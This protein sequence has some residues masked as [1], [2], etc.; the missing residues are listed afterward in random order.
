MAGLRRLRALVFARIA[1]RDLTQAAPLAETLTALSTFADL[2]TDHALQFAQTGLSGRFGVPRTPQGEIAVPVILGMGKLGGGELNFSSDIDLIFAFSESG[3]TD[4][5]KSISN[6]EYFVKVA[7]SV[8]RILSAPTEHGIVFRV[9]WMLRPFGSAGAMAWSF[10]AMEDYYQVHGREWERYA[11]IKA[12]PVAGDIGQGYSLLERLRPFIYRRYLDFNALGALRELKRLIAADALQKGGVDNLK[13]GPGGIR[14]VEFIV[15]SFQLVR[16]GQDGRLRSPCLQPTLAKLHEIG[17][18]QADVSAQLQNAYAFLRRAE[19]A[20]QM[21]DDQQTHNLPQTPESQDS[22]AASAG[23]SQWSAFLTELNQHRQSVAS[24]FA[25]TFSA[26]DSPKAQGAWAHSLTDAPESN[27]SGDDPLLAALASL[28]FGEAT[29]QVAE[30]IATLRRAY[31]VRSLPEH[32][33]IKLQSLLPLVLAEC[34]RS[35]APLAA[36][37]RSLDLLQAIAGRSTYLSLLMEST[38]A[39]AQ[40]VRLCAASPW[41]A[42]MLIRNPSLLDQLL[43]SESL[44]ETP[45]QAAIVREISTRCA[46]VP[47]GDTEALMETLRRC[48]H[49]VT[50]RVAA[51]DLSKSLPLVKVA[52]CLTWLAESV[53]QHALLAAHKELEKT[54]GRPVRSDG[55][56]AAI[57]VLGYGKLGSVEMGYG[58]DL[59]I[60]FI[61]DAVDSDGETV[62]GV[63]KTSA[64]E[65]FAKLAQR[66]VHLLAAQLHSGRAYEVDLQLRPNG[67]SGLPVMGEAGFL[68]YQLEKAWTWEHL[69]LTRA[70]WVA[71]DA[72]LGARLANIR[73]Q[74]LVQAR[75]RGPLLLEI[76][77]MR[78]KMRDHLDKSSESRWDVKHGRG[79]LVDI[80]FITQALLLAHANTHPQI[81]ENADVWRQLEALVAAQLLTADTADGLLAAQRSYRSHLNRA[82][83]QGGDQSVASECF[84]QQRQQVTEIWH[85]VFAPN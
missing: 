58:S 64:Q 44:N 16:G 73:Q 84:A 9:D 1:W 31:L 30:R 50:L 45:T 36:A 68:R 29:A 6:G 3:E 21:W 27:R 70:R 53:L 56:S 62:G 38:A 55:S 2:A 61:H 22:L 57:A 42:A 32:A 59:D 85:Q 65:F 66:V 46:T 7:Q 26:D 74:V 35:S 13:L 40:L 63:R 76:A 81:V 37:E 78:Q 23:H 10:D 19:N 18:L 41:I 72:A 69:A 82:R 77:E 20:L 52:D 33:L 28:N 54:Y 80:E 17:L 83:L 75:A 39:R 15:Q 67:S 60:V 11:L 4:G 71:G 79:G 34:A 8:S 5:V 14:E 43:D 47:V 49:E 25:R 51:A 24:T 48:T 12:R